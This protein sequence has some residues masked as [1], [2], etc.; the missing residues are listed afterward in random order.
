MKERKQSGQNGI[1]LTAE[2]IILIIP[3][4][5][6]ADDDDDDNKISGRITKSGY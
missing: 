3:Y 2:E 4:V 6:A 5:V 1:K